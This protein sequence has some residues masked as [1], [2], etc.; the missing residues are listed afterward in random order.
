VATHGRGFWV[1]DDITALRQIDDQVAAADAW[2]FRPAEVVLIP[3]GSENGTP[4]PKDEPFADNPP[5]GAYIDYYIGG[6]RTSDS[7]P[8]PPVT[9][10]IVDPAGQ[11]IRRVASDQPAPVRDPNTLNVAAVWVTTPQPPSASPGMH[12]WVWDLR[13]A[14]TGGGRGGPGGGRG[15]APLA[16][17]GTYA[18]RLTV[19]D[20]TLTQVLAVKP[21][22]R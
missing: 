22:P 21:D 17:P 13:L 20:K 18:V 2:L 14:T 5:F 9:I 19:N 6:R 11:T 16:Q 12:R 15:G 4:L 3:P 7:G 1:L 8:P 10:E